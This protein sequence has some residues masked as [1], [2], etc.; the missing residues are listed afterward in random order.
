MIGAQ[1]DYPQILAEKHFHKVRYGT[2]KFAFV[3]TQIKI[4]ASYIWAIPR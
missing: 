3:R 4:Y 1:L 2:L